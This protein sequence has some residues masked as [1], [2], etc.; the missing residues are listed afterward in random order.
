IVYSHPDRKGE[1]GYRVGAIEAVGG[2]PHAQQNVCRAAYPWQDRPYVA[3]RLTRAGQ[4]PA[5]VDFGKTPAPPPAKQ[6][7]FDIGR[8]DRLIGEQKP[9]KSGCLII[10]VGP[11]KDADRAL[12]EGWTFA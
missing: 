4:E 6:K 3:R 9:C 1:A 5:V 10:Q 7:P 12:C 2:R 8:L 11:C